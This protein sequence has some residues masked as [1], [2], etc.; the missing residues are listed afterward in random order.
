MSAGNPLLRSFDEELYSA[1]T[2]Y[3][4]FTELYS[5]R[6]EAVK[7]DWDDDEEYKPF[8]ELKEEEIDDEFYRMVGHDVDDFR[9]CYFDDYIVPDENK[10]YIS[11]LSAEYRGYGYVIAETE[12]GLILSTSDSDNYHYAIGIVP[13]FKYDDIYEEVENRHIEN[14]KWY[15]DRNLDFEYYME[16]ESKKQYRKMIRK[17]KKENEPI[18]RKIHDSYG[19]CMSE[20]AGAYTSGSIKEINSK[21]KFL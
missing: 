9:Q 1:K 15:L 18:M 7:K 2:Y 13:N 17:F 10:K 11:E 19:K 12:T 21:F 6:K 20:R 4:D 8:D 14:M 5:D 3:I 16:Q